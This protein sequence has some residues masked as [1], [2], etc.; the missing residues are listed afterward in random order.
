MACM[1][2][3][4]DDCRCISICFM[5]SSALSVASRLCK[6]EMGVYF[7]LTCRL[8]VS[9]KDE[10]LEDLLPRGSGLRLPYDAVELKDTVSALLL[11]GDNCTCFII[12]NK[13]TGHWIM[14]NYVLLF[15]F[16][17]SSLVWCCYDRQ[18]CRYCRW[19]LVCT[20]TCNNCAV[21]VQ[22]FV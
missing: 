20:F 15:Q 3:L 16:A 19:C 22:A 18:I 5:V 12:W 21:F 7:S 14:F 13:E 6:H 4:I 1:C 2:C 17:D 11:N 9:L 10:M 8:L